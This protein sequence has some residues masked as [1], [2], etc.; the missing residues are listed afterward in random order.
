MLGRDVEKLLGGLAGAVALQ[1]ALAEPEHR[2]GGQPVARMRL[3]E[4]AEAHLGLLVLPLHDEGVGSLEIRLR[5]AGA[6]G[7]DA[8]AGRRR[9]GPAGAGEV[10]GSG[11][12]GRGVVVLA[13]L[14]LSRESAAGQRH[15]RAGAGQRR[16]EGGGRRGRAEGPRRAC[17]LRRLARIEGIAAALR[18]LA[19]D[20][21]R[22]RRAARVGRSGPGAAAAAL[23]EAELDVLLELA[24]L[25]LELPVLELELLDLPRELAHLVLEAAE[26]DDGVGG[27]L[28]EGRRRRDQDEAE[29][30]A[31][32]HGVRDRS[33]GRASR[34]H[35]SR[36]AAKVRR[37]PRVPSVAAVALRRRRRRGRSR[38]GGT[39]TSRRCRCR[40]RPAC[41]CRIRRWEAV[42]RDA[43]RMR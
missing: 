36:P 18:G 29:G 13:E 3:Q 12:A 21:P 1:V 35:N 30:K 32:K 23:L 40:P 6:G 26:A 14:I 17:G 34:Y 4:A 9:R 33:V 24:D 20:R 5:I 15:R 31:A 19:L 25:I 37:R 10:E 38:R 11:A 22:R 8:R 41:P 28:R 43:A 39:G 7:G 2:F 16:R 42:A 27:V